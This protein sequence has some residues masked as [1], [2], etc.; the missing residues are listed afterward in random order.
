[1]I[2]NISILLG[3]A[4]QPYL[5]SL[6]DLNLIKLRSGFASGVG[7]IDEENIRLTAALDSFRL[8][9]NG[10]KNWKNPNNCEGSC[11]FMNKFKA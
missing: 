7:D 3:S 10:R 5:L 4:G 11:F 6:I 1:M 2:K 8:A 9:M